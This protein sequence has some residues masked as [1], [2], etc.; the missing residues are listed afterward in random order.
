MAGNEDT[1]RFWWLEEVE[2]GEDDRRAVDDLQRLEGQLH[3]VRGS[4]A[5]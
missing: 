5:R 1:Y 2:D 4:T 3:G